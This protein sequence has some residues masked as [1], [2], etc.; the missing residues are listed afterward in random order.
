MNDIDLTFVTDILKD[1]K[2]E[3]RDIDWYAVIGFL[4][5]H[6]I[7]GMFYMKAKSLSYIFPNKI[8]KILL[9]TFTRQKRRAEFFRSETEKI[10]KCL[11]AEKIEHI[12]LKGSVLCSLNETNRI[13][14]DGERISNDIDILVKPN[15]LSAIC[16][17]LRE[18]GFIQGKYD[19]KKGVIV[20][21]SRMEI[22]K[23]QMNRGETA[24]FVKLTNNPEIPF[25][26]VD[27][28]FSLGNEPAEYSDL[29][30][31]MIRSRKLYSG[32][33]SLYGAN[34]ELFFLHLIMHQFKESRLYFMVE[35][36]KDIDLYKL[37]DMYFLWIKDSFDKKRFKEYVEK[38]K[39]G[40]E[41][42]TV[43]GQIARVFEDKQLLKT[44]KEFG[45]LPAEVYD[46]ATK[47]T[48]RWN[49]D[50]K[51]RLC[52]FDARKFLREVELC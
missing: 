15:G 50:E 3:C 39:L 22:L 44:A 36:S 48:Y 24:P 5:L 11:I 6:K 51:T 26:E 17:S 33:I 37:A 32:K 18:L 4:G 47:A 21:F 40:N 38:Y 7:A 2:T 52:F 25:L 13:Y 34:E 16:K 19:D 45:E 30:S 12:F 28:N 20:P 10:S 8:E 46:Y 41:V 27:V 49:A 31:E 1:V 35:R 23:R 43:L 14:S 9:G 29:I 42:G